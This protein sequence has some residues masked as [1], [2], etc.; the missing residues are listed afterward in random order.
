M[1]GKA[2]E[3]SSHLLL[4]LPSLPHLQTFDAPANGTVSL[5]SDD[6]AAK[7]GHRTKTIGHR[8]LA[9]LEPWPLPGA[10]EYGEI[11]Y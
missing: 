4:S 6:I 1:T 5:Q 7:P 11:E 10:T 3:G 2:L 8:H 9:I